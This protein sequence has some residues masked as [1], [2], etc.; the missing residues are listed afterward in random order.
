MRVAKVLGAVAFL[1]AIAGA[2]VWAIDIR[3]RNA[4]VVAARAY[5][6]EVEARLAGDPRFQHVR[7]TG[8]GERGGAVSVSGEVRKGDLAVLQQI[9]EADAP[10]ESVLYHVVELTPEQF[11]AAEDAGDLT[12]RRAQ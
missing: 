12:P 3:P 1:L 2:V 8:T 11:D 4:R 10:V 9:V 7:L 6:R 5:G